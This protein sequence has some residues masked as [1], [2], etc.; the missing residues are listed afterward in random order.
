M[1]MSMKKA[2]IPAWTMIQI[3]L[4]A[5]LMVWIPRTIH[6]EE[7]GSGHYLPGAAASFIDAL[8]G[9]QAFAYVNMFTFYSGDADAARPIQFGGVIAANID[10]RVY[11][12]TS[13]LLYQTPW[14]IL[15][16]QYAVALA[17]PYIWMEVEGAVRA[18]PLSRSRRDTASGFGDL[19]FFPLML[20][21]TWGDLKSDVRFSVYMP[22][23][24]FEEGKLANVGKNYWTFEP[25]VFV[26]YLS[27]KIGLE[28]SAYAALDFNTENETTDYRS[29]DQFHLDVTI[30]EHLPLFGGFIG[31]GVNGFYY[32]QFTG[33]S[34]DG[35]QLGSFEG[36]TAGIGPV[37]S[38]A[39]KV[40]DTDVVAEVKWV[41]ELDTSHR[42]DGDYIWFKLALVF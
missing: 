29:G 38:Y 15:D 37:L 31:V 2:F 17:I 26:S 8:P 34:G 20:G 30:A 25:G 4:M 27:S 6:A 40:C 11:A 24:G 28:V 42:L 13:L 9:R 35:A 5:S 1:K 36:M 39:T 22:T 32:K 3:L 16:G 10:A 14:K 19:Q 41:T 21:W 12:D 18:G 23:G 33:D 7:G